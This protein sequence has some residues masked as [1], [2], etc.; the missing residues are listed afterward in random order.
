MP[1]IVHKS[2]PN[3]EAM[4]L[5]IFLL[6]FIP[7]FTQSVF[8]ETNCGQ[9]PSG[10]TGR[11]VSARPLKW[12]GDFD[13]D[14]VSDE[15]EIVAIGQSFKKSSAVVIAN[16]WDGNAGRIAKKGQSVALLITHGKNNG[17]CKRYLLVEQDYF[18][19]PIWVSF[20]EGHDVPSPLGIVKAG[21]PKFKTWKR[22][23]PSLMGD[24][25]E[26]YTEAGIEILLYWTMG[27]YEVYWPE[28]E[29]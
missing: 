15:L 6:C 24:S 8:A 21:S 26:L 2:G 27:H 22:D 10:I 12:L 7:I 11:S 18:A 20:L 1:A 17:G 29:P 9:L 4:T 19:T 16:P 3:Q 14:G 23:V 25:I 28:E 13:H 5:R